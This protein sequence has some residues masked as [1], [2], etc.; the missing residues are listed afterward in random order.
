MSQWNEWSQI[1]VE[2]GT[3]TLHCW[4]FCRNNEP[5]N[6]LMRR[7]EGSLGCLMEEHEEYEP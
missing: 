5:R 1:G 2:C 7:L 3:D 6:S 4:V